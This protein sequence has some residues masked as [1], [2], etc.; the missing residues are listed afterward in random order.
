[1][2]HFAQLDENN[3]VT[4]VIVVNN[5]DT[6]DVIGNEQ[7][8][9]GVAFCERLFGGR[10]KQTSY[11]GNMRKRYAGIGYSYNE[12]LDAFVRPKPYPSW[13]FNSETAD[14]DPPVPRPTEGEMLYVWDEESQ[15]WNGI[16]P[17]ATEG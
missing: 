16:P 6:R 17:P 8:H 11:N 2:A 3:I 5:S 14:W 13:T 10:W 12:E 7:E 1:M 9:I 15:A 4:Q